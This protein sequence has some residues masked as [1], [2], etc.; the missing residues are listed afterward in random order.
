[1]YDE[2]TASVVAA[3]IHRG[4]DVL[5]VC[6]RGPNDKA[7]KWSLPGGRV[8]PGESLTEALRREVREETG[9]E[10]EKLGRLVNLCTLLVEDD[11]YTC[12]VYEVNEWHGDPSPADPDGFVIEARFLPTADAMSLVEARPEISRKQPVIAYLRG[13]IVDAESWTY[14]RLDNGSEALVGREVLA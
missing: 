3:I 7:P 9:L 11:G 1:L 12:A 13:E 5:F 8:E 4:A 6:E 10:V 2:S 14:R